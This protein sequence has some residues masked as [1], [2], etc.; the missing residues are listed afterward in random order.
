MDIERVCSLTHAHAIDLSREPD[1]VRAQI[2]VTG[3]FAA[4]DGMLTDEEN[5]LLMADLHRPGAARKLA[6]AASSTAELST[7][8]SPSVRR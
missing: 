7:C 8:S 1:A 6:A 4:V 2:G 5:L 3:Q